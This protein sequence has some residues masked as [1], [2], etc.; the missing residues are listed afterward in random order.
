MSGTPKFTRET[1]R[2]GLRFLVVGGGTAILQVAVITVLKRYMNETV[3]YLISWALSTATHYFANRF[4]ALPSA[5]RDTARQF[6]EYIFTVLLTCAISTGAFKLCRD[7]VGMS[8][9]WATLGAIPPSTIVVFLLL[10]YRV[11]RQKTAER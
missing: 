8:V 1:V 11:F 3:A 6:G 2:R 5:R 9:E 10:N 4:W 7:V